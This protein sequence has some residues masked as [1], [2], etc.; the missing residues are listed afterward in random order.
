LTGSVT[1]GCLLILRLSYDSVPL[2]EEVSSCFEFLGHGFMDLGR[3]LGKRACLFGG[4]C[5]RV[6]IKGAVSH[7]WGEEKISKQNKS[8]IDKILS[9]QL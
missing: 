2:D 7:V 6:L 5:L 9:T 1:G 3:G 8:T 4:W